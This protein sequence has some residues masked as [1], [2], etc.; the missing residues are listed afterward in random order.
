MMNIPKLRLQN[1]QLLLSHFTAPDEI[2]S[3]MGAM[4]AQD[5]K[6]ALRAV[7]IRLP[8]E[9]HEAVEASFNGG[10]FLRTHILRPTWHFVSP[11]DIRWMLEL[12]APN[13]KARAHSR[14][15][16]LGI[17]ENI[18]EKSNT[19]LEQVLRG[20]K[21]QT[22]EALAQTLEDAGID[23]CDYRIAHL[24]MR[25]ELDAVICSGTYIGGKQ[26]YALLSERAPK[27]KR[28]DRDTSLHMLAKR[29]FSSRGPALLK[30]FVWWSGMT[31]TDTRRG[32]LLAGSELSST[33]ID[34][35]TYYYNPTLDD[36][37]L[38][39]GTAHLLPAFD[40]YIIA[41]ADRSAVIA[42]AH[43]AKAISSNGIFHPT[44][45]RDGIVIGTWKYKGK[46]IEYIY[47]NE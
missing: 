30:D 23:T 14:D 29:Y 25:A 15:L 38:S 1:Q 46:R 47:F 18:F 3:W 34:G 5:F 22:R 36:A 4:Q 17:D 16:A 37:E 26:T 33:D 35:Q 28:F 10:G 39:P 7:A 21:H 2:V 6:S 32:I 12:T 45:L 11:E 13:V 19:L 24:L 44:I 31:V 8:G 41:Y 9:P 42:A 20:E 27:A 43:T 40:E